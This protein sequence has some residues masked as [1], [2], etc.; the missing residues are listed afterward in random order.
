MKIFEV[1]FKNFEIAYWVDSNFLQKAKKDNTNCYNELLKSPLASYLQKI[2]NGEN[3]AKKTFKNSLTLEL[4]NISNSNSFFN[5]NSISNH[6]DQ[7]D[8]NDEIV[9]MKNEIEQLKKRLALYEQKF[10]EL[11]RQLE[12]KDNHTIS[13]QIS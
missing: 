13:Y 6:S 4:S 8:R 3:L 10:D 1:F 7:R 5:N 11:Q 12:T 9:M 2:E